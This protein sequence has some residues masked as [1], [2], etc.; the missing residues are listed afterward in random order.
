MQLEQR[1]ARLEREARDVGRGSSGRGVVAPG[2]M[3]KV[4]HVE[5]G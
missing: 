3:R 5:E 2:A 1:L 4:N